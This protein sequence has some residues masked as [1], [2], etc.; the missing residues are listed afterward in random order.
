MFLL[1]GLGNA[2]KKYLDTRHNI[3]FK[4]LDSVINKYNLSFVKEKFKGSFYNGNICNIK[5]LAIKPNTMMN[6]SGLSVLEILNY[7]KINTKNIIVMH[8]DLD[9]NVGKM[10]IKFSGGTGGHNGIKSIDSLIGN[11]YFRI[12]IGIGHPGN[13]D[14]V[15]QY[16]LNRFSSEELSLVNSLIKKITNNFFHI[17]KNEK[18]VFNKNCNN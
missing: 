18:D 11:D 9:L 12:K 8:D 14:A 5:I 3:G 10:K 4:L 7:F 6:L 16:V 13:K 2:D 17:I 15:S 1:V